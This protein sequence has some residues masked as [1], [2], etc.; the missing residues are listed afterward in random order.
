MIVALYLAPLTFTQTLFPGRGVLK[1]P[2]GSIW[3]ILIVISSPLSNRTVKN[4]AQTII[5]HK[6]LLSY[7][8]TSLLT[9]SSRD[10]EGHVQRA[11][12]RSRMNYNSRTGK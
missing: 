1:S 7:Y 5:A 6:S 4:S 11:H 10:W 9:A 2:S 12:A 3:P 8:F